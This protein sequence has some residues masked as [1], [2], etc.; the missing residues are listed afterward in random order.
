MRSSLSELA[1][2]TSGIDYKKNPVGEDVPIYGTGGIMGYTSVALNIG[3]AVLSGR[4]GSINNPFYVVG[5]FW[6]VDTIFCIKA[7][8]GVDTKWLYYHFLN[9]DLS[10]LNE[11]TGVPSISSKALY[12]IKFKWFELPIQSKI[13]NILST[14]DAVIEKTQA[15][16]A[17]YKAIKQ[18]MLHDLFTRGIDPTNGT[19]RPTYQ[20]APELYKETKLGMVPKDWEVGKFIDYITSHSY[21]PRFS[22]NQY[23]EKGNIK[24]IR[25]MD[26]TKE[27]EIL[28][29]QVPIANLNKEIVCLLYTS[30]SPRD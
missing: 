2:I 13:A 7:M 24:T 10:K 21:G 22:S 19:L 20:A 28:Y 1:E 4:K 30:P 8:V 3:P 17:K 12:K 29:E 23:S 18:G 6:N 9:Y 11:A 26:F 25:G 14:C 15:A 16:I 5:P 27:G